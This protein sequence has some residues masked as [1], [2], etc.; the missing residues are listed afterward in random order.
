MNND[1]FIGPPTIW[2]VLT[3]VGGIATALGLIVTLEYVSRRL[4][5]ETSSIPQSSLTVSVE[6]GLERQFIHS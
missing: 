3:V 4:S 5:P 2:V 6:K 1:D